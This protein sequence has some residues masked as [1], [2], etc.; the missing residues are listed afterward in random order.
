MMLTLT[1]A[2]PADDPSASRNRFCSMSSCDRISDTH[3]SSICSLLTLYS[4]ACFAL[5][6]SS[7]SSKH[8]LFSFLTDVIS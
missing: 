1:A 7:S 4:A 2:F 5:F 6:T 8:F 3:Q